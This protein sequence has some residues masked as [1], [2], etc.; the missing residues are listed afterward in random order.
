MSL[1]RK[2][3]L[4]PLTRAAIW[5]ALTFV[6]YVF[7]T[8]LRFGRYG[9]WLL[10]LGGALALVLVGKLIERRS[11]AEIG[12][13]G[14]GALREIAGGFG[15]AAGLMATVI[16]VMAALGWYRIVAYRGD[17]QN[18]G[19]MFASFFFVA[20][21]EEVAMRGVLFR[22]LEE[23]VGSWIALIFNGLVFGLLHLGNANASL[24]A[25]LAIAVEAGLLLTAAFMYTRS[26]WLAIGLHWG[27]NFMQGSV[28]GAPVSGGSG[29]ALVGARITGPAW[30]TGGAFGP[31]AGLICLV[32]GSAAGLWLLWLAVRRGHVVRPAWSRRVS[33]GPGSERA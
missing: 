1:G 6:W 27:W 33:T 10:A 13:G 18:V 24:V 11:M 5:M 14:R 32:V 23:S 7:V 31:E 20:L 2:I 12:F 28:F 29:P 30:A 9:N 25:S 26:L 15:L 3:L 19:W 22:M 4:F 8:M 17:W 16:G 21:I